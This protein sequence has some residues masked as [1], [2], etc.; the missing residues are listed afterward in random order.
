MATTQRDRRLASITAAALVCAISTAAAL[1][2]TTQQFTVQATVSETCTIAAG[3][4]GSVLSFGT[5]DPNASASTASANVLSVTCT[6]GGTTAQVLLNSGLNASTGATPERQM[7]NATHP[8]AYK[9][10]F[11]AALHNEW[12]A[13]NGPSIVE[14]GNAHDLTVYGAIDPGQPVFVGTY[15]DTVTA[16]IT[17]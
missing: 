9:L 17:F 10:F 16:T 1:A 12:N 13:T 7:M 4:G 3:S 11:D 5:Y 8:L 2:A 14:D 15:S 6:N